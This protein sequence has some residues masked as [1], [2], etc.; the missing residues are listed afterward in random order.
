MALVALLR[1]GLR[2]A[3]TDD[4]IHAH[5]AKGGSVARKGLLLALGRRR[6]FATAATIHG[7][8]FGD[9]AERHPRITGALLRQCDI[10]LTLSSELEDHVRRLAPSVPVARVPNPVAVDADITG[11]ETSDPIVVFAGEVGVRKGVDVLAQAWPAVRFAVP[12]ARL[13][14]AGP[15]TRLELPSLDGV[16]L[17]GPVPREQIRELMRSARLV[18]LPSR[19]E[20]LPMALLEAMAVGR[21]FVSTPC[22]DIPGLASG[23]GGVIVPVGDAAALGTAMIAFLADPDMAGRAGRAAHAHC[24]RHLSITGLRVQ[25]NQHYADARARAAARRASP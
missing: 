3:D 19:A 17:L 10:V 1:I 22:G 12:A 7:S 21:P 23:G 16:E 20:A 9:F 25:M 24:A 2:R 14:V 11:A 8:S 18:V 5:V 15:R 4:V 6:G 13:V